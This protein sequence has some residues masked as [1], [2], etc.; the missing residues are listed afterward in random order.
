[1][2]PWLCILFCELVAADASPDE[3]SKSTNAFAVDLY[4]MIG[5]ANNGKNLFFSSISISIAFGM[6]GLG[7]RG[8]TKEQTKAIL[9][10]D[11]I[12]SDETL[13]KVYKLLLISFKDRA[14]NYTLQMVDRLFGSEVFQ[15]HDQF[16]Q[17]TQNYFEASLEHLDFKGNAEESRRHINKWVYTGTDKPED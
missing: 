3:L 12:S 7:A 8:K 11:K 10:V 16:I 6:I 4:K 1:M 17:E 15:F 9:H 5:D 13:E 14:N 2:I